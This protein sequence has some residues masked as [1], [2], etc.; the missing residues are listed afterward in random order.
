M[1]INGLL[2]MEKTVTGILFSE[3]GM[4]MIGSRKTGN[5]YDAKYLL[6]DV[7]LWNRALSQEELLAN[8]T[9]KLSGKEKGL[10][11]FMNFDDTFKDISGNGND[12]IP[13]YN[14]T[15]EV[16]DFDPP[17][18][19]FEMYQLTNELTFNNKTKNATSWLWDFGN[20]STSQQGNPKH[21]Y[22]TSGEYSVSFLAKNATTVTAAIGHV[23]IEG[24][25]R[26]EPQKAGNA[27][28]VTITVFGGALTPVGTEFILRKE[29][30]ADIK[31]GNLYSPAP[32]QL[33]GH[34]IMTGSKIGKWNV[35]VKKDGKELILGEAFNVVEAI[36]PD[37]W[38]SVS[39]R[40]LILFNMW[41]TYA[42]NYG[43]KGNV[44]ALGVPLNIVISDLPGMDIEFID[45]KVEANEYMKKNT[46]RIVELMDTLYTV[47]EDYFGPGKNAR[48][49]PLYIPVVGSNSSKSIHIRIKSPGDFNIETWTS[50]PFIQAIA[51]TKSAG[52]TAD[53]WPDEK[54]KLNACI[55]LSAMHAASSSA[56]D[57]LGLVLPVDCVYDFSTLILGNPW[58][59][60]KPDHQRSAI[61][62]HRGYGLASAI[63]SCAG[64]LSPWKAV[65]IAF[66]V[67]S[68]INNMYQGYKAHQDC[69]NAFD[70]RYKNKK[71][72]RAV[73]SFDPNEMIGPSGFGTQNYIAKYNLMPYTVLFENKSTATAPAHVVTIID[74]LDLSKFDISEFGFGSFGW[75]TSIYNPLGNKLKEFSM[76]IDMRPGTNLIT[77]VSGKLDTITGII[78]WDFLSL[79]PSTMNLEEDPF[80]GFLPP[81]K[82]SPQGEG[83]VSFS[84]G[85]K[86]ELKT[87][88]EI[89]NKASIVFDANKPIITNNYLNT[90]DL[91]LPESKVY[92]LNNALENHF[93]LEWTGSDKGSGIQHYSI[94]VLVNDTLLYPW[95]T[96]TT[97]LSAPFE[98]GEIGSTYKF[99]S[100]ATDNVY[101]L[102]NAP[103]DYDAVTTITVDVEE[104]ERAKENLTVW[105]NPVRD[106]LQVSLSNAPCGV[107]VIELVGC[108]RYIET[109]SQIYPDFELQNGININV[110]DCTPGQYVLRI[111]YGNKTE[112]RKIVVQ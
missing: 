47:V 57:A 26:V 79:N 75:D 27:G 55:A 58:D 11:L 35:V 77:R 110:L 7:R 38:V 3:D 39:G 82:T 63:L 23:T 71:G 37:P 97:D 76:D 45:F 81:N 17:F 90:L 28:F 54:T 41:Q 69:L 65:K 61:L 1:Y 70:P 48:F 49:Y 5:S 25:D 78:K 53:D 52:G 13:V 2:H 62:Q 72:V 12:G 102:E 56:M 103:T 6:D 85:L 67:T 43:N 84:V 22:T 14:G 19:A 10:K 34:F 100:I 21:T 111:V 99:Y 15:L 46:P 87:N 98:I 66:K 44:D 16:S 105:P 40:G 33:A 68:I 95:I 4:L 8:Q 32:G 42:I 59:A 24:L 101:H 80:I 73:S 36:Q 92:P 29:G 112:T 89:R 109:F 31:G 60:A 108:K 9:K 91:D 50:E 18:A 30:S 83:F 74:T 86:K 107:Y 94:Y 51:P 106:N 104:F 96:N 88:A 93:L 20:K 64:D